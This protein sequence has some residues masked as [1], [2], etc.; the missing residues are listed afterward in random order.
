MNIK[1]FFTILNLVVL[2]YGSLNTKNLIAESTLS[3]LSRFIPSPYIPAAIGHEGTHALMAKLLYPSCHPHL[4]IGK[5]LDDREEIPLISNRHFSLY[6]LNGLRNYCRYSNYPE[7]PVK[8]KEIAINASGPIAGAATSY[9]SHSLTLKAFNKIKSKNI[10]VTGLKHA[11]ITLPFTFT[12]A[13]NLLN[14]TPIYTDG[15]RIAQDLG[16]SEE[17]LRPFYDASRTRKF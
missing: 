5:S 10:F 16:V 13:T 2:S 17:R 9:Y 6:S 3:Y 11:L 8:H 1:S 4:V 15:Y 7:N 14:L 12:T